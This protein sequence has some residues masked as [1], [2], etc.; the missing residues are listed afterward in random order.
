[1]T[2]KQIVSKFLDWVGKRPNLK[3]GISRLETNGKPSRYLVFSLTEYNGD[4]PWTSV[5][6][7][8]MPPKTGET[9][10]WYE[11]IKRKCSG[12]LALD[13]FSQIGIGECSSIEEFLLKLEI[14]G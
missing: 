14:T 5:C 9:A 7:E 6:Y 8:V 3:A 2:K 13:Q 11:V 1:M 12:E 10:G 4:L